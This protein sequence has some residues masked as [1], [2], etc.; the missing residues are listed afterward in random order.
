MALIKCPEC[1]KQISD[2][3]K[4]CIHCGCP[5][6]IENKYYCDECGKEVFNNEMVC[7]NCG[8]PINNKKVD[9]KQNTFNK[10]KLFKLDDK[11]LL[12]VAIFSL[13]IMMIVF[14]MLIKSFS[15]SI[16]IATI[17]T[18]IY[19]GALVFIYIYL[20]N[21]KE[22]LNRK[23]T[24]AVIRGA[25]IPVIIAIILPFTKTEWTYDNINYAIERDKDIEFYYLYTNFLGGCEYSYSNLGK[26]ISKYSSSCKYEKNGTTYTFWITYEGTKKESS[27][28]C[29]LVDGKLRC[30]L[31]NRY[32]KEYINLKK[33]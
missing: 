26:D 19:F 32:P 12:L 25:F 22:N 27:F 18:I 9:L 16:T 2:K 29:N 28:D 15:F 23:K 24:I 20:K 33:N 3:A 30:P 6:E 7:S 13:L 31:E 4:Q 21:N 5:I 14:F 11:S 8:C 1:K 10:D 17:T